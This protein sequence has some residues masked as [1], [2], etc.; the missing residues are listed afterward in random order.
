MEIQILKSI[1]TTL[2]VYGDLYDSRIGAQFVVQLQPVGSIVRPI[3]IPDRQDGVTIADLDLELCVALDLIVVSQ[4]LDRRFW[5]SSKRNLHH[6]LFRLL[7]RRSI[8]ETW[9]NVSLWRTL[10]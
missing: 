9:R 10:K 1:A 7:E 6:D 5:I 2:T 3:G 4:P 8:L